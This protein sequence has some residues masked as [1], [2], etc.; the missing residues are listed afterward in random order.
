MSLFL[1]GLKNLSQL[2]ALNIQMLQGR[3]EDS[4]LTKTLAANNGRLKFV[5]FDEDSVSLNIPE[6]DEIVSY[7]NIEELKVN[8][9]LNRLFP[10]LFTFLPNVRHLYVMLDEET[11]RPEFNTTFTNLPPLVH[12]IDFQLRSSNLSWTLDEILAVLCPMSSLQR[13]TLD[14]STD[15]ECLVKGENLALLLPSSVIQIHVCIRYYFPEPSFETDALLASWPDHLPITCL[16]D[17]AWQRVL[18]YTILF[19]LCSMILPAEL[20]KQMSSGWKYLQQVEDLYI[21]NATSL[22]QIFLVLQHFHQ[23]RRLTI[24][25]QNKSEARMHCLFLISCVHIKAF[26]NGELLTTANDSGLQFQ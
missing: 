15:D 9:N 1:D 4:L 7:P 11:D 8:V 17:E 18:L 13:L 22:A 26:F 24:S 21:Y 6:G 25:T 10:R 19:N 2:V 23:L 3:V 14:L 16:L 5:S 20:G 12:L